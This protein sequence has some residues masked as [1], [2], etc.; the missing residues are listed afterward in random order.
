MKDTKNALSAI[1]SYCWDLRRKELHCSWT[2][3]ELRHSNSLLLKHREESCLTGE[4]ESSEKIL[5]ASETTLLERAA[6]LE[7]VSAQKKNSFLAHHTVQMHTLVV[8]VTRY[9]KTDYLPK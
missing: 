4:N 6:R 9:N 5:H 3:W 1:T 7:W 2:Q 8:Y